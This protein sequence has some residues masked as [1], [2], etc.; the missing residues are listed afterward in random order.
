MI[1]AVIR[2][3]HDAKKKNDESIEI[4]GDGLSRREFMYVGDFAD[5]MYYA[6]DHFDL[7]PQNINV[8]LGHDFSITEY[9]KKISSIVGYEGTFSHDLSRPTGM[10]QKLIDDTKLQ[11]FGWQ[12]QTSLEEGLQKTYY[13]FLNEVDYE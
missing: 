3:I 8:G 13:Y 9:Y 11:K 7:M 10:K 6:I 1:P 4:W 5:F 12:H 2:K